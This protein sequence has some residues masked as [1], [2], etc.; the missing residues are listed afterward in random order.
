MH[1]SV[2]TTGASTSIAAGQPA[3]AP[4][5]RIRQGTPAHRYVQ[6]S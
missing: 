2:A 4:I 3:A 1:G 5:G 6:R